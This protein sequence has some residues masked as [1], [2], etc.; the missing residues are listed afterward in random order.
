MTVITTREAIPVYLAGV[1]Y[2]CAAAVFWALG[3]VFLKKGLSFLDHTEMA[4]SRT[5]G[6]ALASLLFCI[7]DPNAYILWRFPSRLLL[8]VFLNILVGNVIG[9]LCYFR[10]LELIGVSKAVGTTSCYPLF[11]TVIS[12]FWLRESVTL[13][14]VLGTAVMIAGLLMLKSGGRKA[15]GAG[16]ETAS[17]KGFLLALVAAFCW[18]AVMVLQK[19]L[20]SVHYLPAASITLWRA[21]FLFAVSWGI[22]AWRTRK[23]PEKRLHLLRA[24]RKIWAYALAAG[25]FG[26]AA[27]GYVFA[28]AIQII[29]VSVATPIT[30]TSPLIAAGMGVFLF[31]ESMRPVQW[32]G[33]LCILG[34]VLTVS[35]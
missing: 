6:F 26:L 35:A 27:G 13:P 18:A 23:E 25:T 5:I 32:A 9:D 24:P 14:L 15:A 28:L 1:L 22:W 10:S 7:L 16:P 17:W 2:C 19:W 31:H 20:L 30:A 3:P 33:I 21:L 11:V 4:A 8:F 34:G 29:P 12:F